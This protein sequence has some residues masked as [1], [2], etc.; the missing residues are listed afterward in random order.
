M[1]WA[2]FP[3]IL[4]LLATG[5]VSANPSGEAV[6]DATAALANAHAEALLA[7]GGDASVQTGVALIGALDAGCGR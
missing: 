4:P 7:D 1:R 2:I 3:V 5:C 6:C